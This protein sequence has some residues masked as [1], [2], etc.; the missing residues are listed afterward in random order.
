MSRPHNPQNGYITYFHDIISSA[1]GSL[2]KS[3]VWVVEFD[4]LREYILPGIQKALSYE[5][6]GWDV[7]TAANVICSD[8]YQKNAG[9]I[10]CQGI[11]VP[12]QDT[13]VMP[14]G[15][16]QYNGFLR[17]YVGQGR[18]DNPIMRMTFLETNVSF[19]D[20]VLR[21]W[22][23][24]TATFGMVARFRRTPENYR[25]NLE[26]WQ[27]G[28]RNTPSGPQATVL[29]H[30]TFYDICCI[31]VNNEELNY[32]GQTQPAM[33]EAQFVYNYYTVD[34]QGDNALLPIARQG[35]KLFGGDATL[36]QTVG[37]P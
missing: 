13:N 23:I 34:S 3:P 18:V 2:I 26:C 1:A 5:P 16:I 32:I 14:E 15:N 33:R 36:D 27:I 19:A 11:D 20:N 6:R 28:G 7:N 22:A 30:F 8:G 35:L 12:G 10:I 21:P 17:S 37:V 9:C 4:N 29:K 31:S 25:T 24:S